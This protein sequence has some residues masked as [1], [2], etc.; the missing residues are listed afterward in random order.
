MVDVSQQA[1]GHANSILSP[2]LAP[3]TTERKGSTSPFRQATVQRLLD[4]KRG[5]ITAE[6]LQR[7]FADHAN[8]PASICRHPR[9]NGTSP[10]TTGAFVSNLTD[11][12]MDIA[13]GNPCLAP[14]KRYGMDF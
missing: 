9:Q 13:I 4:A 12:H 14:F 3:F 2:E 6:E 1:Y 11:R 10:S 5:A 8:F 7:I